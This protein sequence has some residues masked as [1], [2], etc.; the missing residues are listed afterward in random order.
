MPSEEWTKIPKAEMIKLI[1]E[2]SNNYSQMFKRLKVAE[3]KISNLEIRYHEMIE[4]DSENM[5]WRR[6]MEERLERLE[7]KN[8]V[9]TASCYKQF[10]EIKIKLDKLEVKVRRLEKK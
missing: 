9:L 2:M 6:I 1:D 5:V 4:Y 3:T 7:I 8:E 10:R